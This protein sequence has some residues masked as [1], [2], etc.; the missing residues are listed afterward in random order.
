MVMKAALEF[1][2]PGTFEDTG[3]TAESSEAQADN[4]DGTIFKFD[5]AKRFYKK[6]GSPNESSADD[7]KR[8]TWQQMITDGYFRRAVSAKG[9]ADSEGHNFFRATL[10]THSN[11]MIIGATNPDSSMSFDRSLPMVSR[12]IAQQILVSP[13]DQKNIDE[14]RRY[15]E[16]HEQTAI[17]KQRNRVQSISE[18]YISS[19]PLSPC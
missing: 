10:E 7:S 9:P 13:A 2:I 12:L 14:S 5:E 3:R 17:T 16:P 11:I 8:R 15:L 19:P 18:T 1:C 4:F 6:P